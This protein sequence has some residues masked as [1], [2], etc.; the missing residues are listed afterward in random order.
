VR[1]GGGG[2]GKVI[3][4]NKLRKKRVVGKAPTGQAR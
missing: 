4:C 3:Y 1:G 2:G